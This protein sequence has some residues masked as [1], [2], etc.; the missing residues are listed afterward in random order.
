VRLLASL[1]SLT[2]AGHR[3]ICGLDYS[4]AAIQSMTL[5]AVERKMDTVRYQQADACALPPAMHDFHCRAVIDKGTLDAIASGGAESD[6]CSPDPARLATRYLQ[7]MWRILV[8][9]GRF[10]IVSTMPPHLFDLLAVAIVPSQTYSVTPLST[11]EGGQV[12]FY[13]LERRQPSL[14]GVQSG[15]LADELAAL[16]KEAADAERELKEIRARVG[17]SLQ[18]YIA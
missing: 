5:R 2:T 14:A 16:L 10:L 1:P 15:A 17:H 9:G 4:A 3:S 6:S 13:S 11:P 12:Y 8:P 7:E 18:L